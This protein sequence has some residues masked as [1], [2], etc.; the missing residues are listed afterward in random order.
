LGAVKDALDVDGSGSNEVEADA[1]VAGTEAEA[2]EGRPEAQDVAG[3][4]GGEMKDGV[5]DLAG[6][7]RIEAAEIAEGGR[8]PDDDYRPSS[9]LSSSVV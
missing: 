1:P 7:G 6:D 2:F 9:R 8:L 4:G 3:A 5:A